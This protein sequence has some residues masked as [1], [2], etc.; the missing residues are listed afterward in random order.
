MSAARWNRKL[1]RWGASAVTLPLLLVIGTGILLQLG[2]EADWI[3]PTTMKGVGG[4]PKSSSH[5]SPRRHDRSRR[6]PSSPLCG[7]PASIC[8]SSPT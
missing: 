4:P 7:A 1:H 2:K 6:P 5:E 3:Q 8:S